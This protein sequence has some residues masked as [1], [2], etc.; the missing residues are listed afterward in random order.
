[1]AIGMPRGSRKILL[2]IFDAQPIHVLETLAKAPKSFTEVLRKTALPK[3]TLHRTVCGLTRSR[4]VKKVGNQYMMTSDGRLV[5][6]YIKR[7]YV[8]S[9]LKI[10]DDG[11]RRV[12]KQADRTLRM[13]HSGVSRVEQFESVQEA[14]E[15]VEVIGM[16][17]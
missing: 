11:V 4:F 5:L 16:P 10:T 7:L 6:K 8:R 13:E 9:T 2:G 14:V 15:G 12:L 17:A 3:A 1:M